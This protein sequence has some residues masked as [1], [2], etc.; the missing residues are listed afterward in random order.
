MHAAAYLYSAHLKSSDYR[1][2]GVAEYILLHDWSS[3]ACDSVIELVNFLQASPQDSEAAALLVLLS[4]SVVAGIAK[5]CSMDPTHSARRQGPG[6]VLSGLDN[7]LQQHAPDK[8]TSA[9]SVIGGKSSFGLKDIG[10]PARAHPAPKVVQHRNAHGF[11]GSGQANAVAESTKS[12]MWSHEKLYEA[13]N[14]LHALAKT[15]KKPFDAP[16]VLVV[17]HQT[18]GKSALVEALMGFQFNHV[19]GGTKTRR[20]IALHMKYD[21]A[22]TEPHCFLVNDSGQDQE[23]SLEELR[24]YIAH[25]NQRLNAESRFQNK[26]IT[27]KIHYKYCPNLTIVD[28]PGLISAATGGKREKGGLVQASQQ[29][30]AMVKAKMALPEY[31]ILCLED[32]SDWTN[33]TTR[34]LVMSVDPTLARTVV[35]STK[36]D[37]RIPQFATAADADAFLHPSSA[38]LG[39]A[40]ML[41]TSPFFTSV[42]SGR[43]GSAKDSVFHSN[44]DFRAAVARQESQDGDLVAAK[45]QRSL[46]TEEGARCGV[47]RLRSFLEDLLRQRYLENV[48]SIVALLDKEFRATDQQ[49]KMVMAEVNDMNR[50]NLKER[51]RSFVE[52]FLAKLSLLLRGTTTA[53]AARFG[54]TLQDEHA[55]GGSFAASATTAA[56]DLPNASLRLYGGAQYNRAMAEFRAV[57]S[58]MACP[59]IEREEVM[60][61]CGV[62]DFHDGAN[63]IRTACVV[64]MAK[65]RD[66]LEPYL[67]QLGSRL[68][69]VLRRMLPITMH[70]L[71]KDGQYPTGHD[72]FLKRIGAAFVDFVERTQAEVY[73]KCKEDL[74]STTRYIT[75]SL[76][77]RNGFG[78]KH[79]IGDVVHTGDENS[80]AMIAAPARGGGHNPRASLHSNA[81]LTHPITDVLDGTLWNRQL[82]GV[83]EDIVAA[84]AQQLFAGIRDYLVQAVEMKFNC[85]FLMPVIDVFPV[86]LRAELESAYEADLD[87]VFDVAAAKRSLDRKRAE[88]EQERLSW[89][90]LQRKFADIQGTLSSAAAAA[91]GGSS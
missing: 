45:L 34:R 74:V 16:S 62:D 52:Q 13:Y 33:A 50:S 31:I 41:G 83:S 10:S 7:S 3:C 9:G 59:A 27:V 24:E 57:V 51:G 49:L 68:A 17:G 35:V 80:P 12:E 60:N 37:T 82:G 26:D 8:T 66:A 30:E 90:K 6:R 43:V 32:S 81:I 58:T 85:F 1:L 71:Q 4:V 64:G 28:T 14:D 19:G 88:L 40:Q 39:G 79:I 84:L 70:L 36:F 76:H 46:D 48:P 15:F 20:P 18:D 29:V 23:M 86:R 53:P 61:A 54:E 67:Q 78:L 89:E 47:S 56:P 42:P 73:S 65:A 11:G 2:S 77:T 87:A 22:C 75:W 25:E 72:L 38:Q 91:G 44:D 55:K 5:R 21:G 69:H 63:V